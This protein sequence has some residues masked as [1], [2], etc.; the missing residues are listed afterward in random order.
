MDTYSYSDY[1]MSGSATS[2]A[3]LSGDGA[4]IFM[5]IFFVFL[6]IAIIIGILTIVGLW[7]MFTKAGKPGW[8]AIVPIYN[9]VIMFEIVGRPGWWVLL[10]FIPVVNVVIACVLAIDLARSYG[11]S[12]VFGVLTFLFPP[13]MYM[14]L[15][16]DSSTYV[17]PVASTDGGVAQPP[18]TPQQA[19]AQQAQVSAPA[20]A[21]SASPVLSQ[22]TPGEPA[23][24]FETTPDEP[25]TPFVENSD[26]SETSGSEMTQPKL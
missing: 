15:G 24:P 25:A 19:A 17:G 23:T 4:G 8:A 11:K 1:G 14:I 2:T 13:I 18:M 16:F 9:M 12:T 21:Q 3:S 20:S 5:A 26:G 6:L 22:V 10:L 7:K